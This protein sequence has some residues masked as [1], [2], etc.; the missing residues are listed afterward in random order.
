MTRS[1]TRRFWEIQGWDSTKEVYSRRV[2]YGSISE[3]RLRALLAALAAKHGLT[4]DETVDSYLNPKAKGH[5]VHLEVQL[6]AR[7]Y[8]LSCGPNPYFHARIVED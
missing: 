7:P 8:T 3:Q 5:R 2:P 6:Q 1:K 4:D